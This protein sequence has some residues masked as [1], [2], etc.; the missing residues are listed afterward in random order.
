[1]TTTGIDRDILAYSNCPVPNALL[2]ALESNLLAGNGISLNV[3]SGAQAGLHFTYDH[4]AYTRFGGEIPPL[5]S[6][7]L[8]APGR[9]RLLGITP[10]AGRQGIYVRADSPVTSPEQLRGRRVGVSGA[11]IRILTG[12]L[13]DYR[14][15]DP[16]RQTLIALGTW[17]ARGL[18]QTLHIGGIGISDVELVRI[19]SPGVDVPEER[20]E[21]AASVKGADLFP[22]VA[23]HQSDILSSGNVDALFTW[24]PWA[25]ELEDLSG[26]RVLA[27]LGDDKRNRY[28]SVWTVSAQLV[29]E[30]PDLVQRLVDA[31]VQAGRWAQ[32][33]PEDTVGIHA[34]NLGVA[35]SAIGRGFGA[36]FAQH[37]IPRLDDSALAVVDQTQQFLIDHNLLDHPV[38]LTQWAA[39][40]FLTQ[41]TTG[42]QQ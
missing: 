35:P 33:H 27:D 28:A 9:T 19:E 8:R 30:R 26:A 22:D 20:L 36:D 13:G 21:A 2:T 11:A 41:S 25:A 4:P 23:A 40:Q 18:L 24:L 10:L 16:W 14:Q 15:L 42:D 31:A 5:I 32:A 38:D 3:L 6:E 12:E 39:P 29:D 1:M 34:A 7:G 17:E 37:L